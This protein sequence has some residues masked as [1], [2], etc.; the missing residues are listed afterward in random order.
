MRTNYIQFLK[1]NVLKAGL[2]TALGWLTSGTAFAQISGNYTINRLGTASATVYTS[3]RAVVDDL[4]GLS[5]SDGGVANNTGLGVTGAVTYRV[6]AGSGP[7]TWANTN[8]LII[9]A[10]PTT[11]SVRTVTFRGNNEI[12][13][14]TGSSSE[15]AAIMLDGAD[16]FRFDSIRLFSL[17]TTQCMGM[18]FKNNSDDNIVRNCVV[19]CPNVSTGQTATGSMSA[20]IAF[21]TDNNNLGLSQWGAN[22]FGSN[23]SRNQFIRNSIGGRN[24][25][26]SSGAGPAYGIMIVGDAGANGATSNVIEENLISNCFYRS[27]ASAF[28][29]SNVIN[30]NN[31][32][33]PDVNTQ[34]WGSTC[35]HSEAG[36]AGNTG[37]ITISNNKMYQN[38]GTN[39][40]ASTA[41][42]AI[43]LNDFSSG[44][45]NVF[46]NSIYDFIGTSQL[47]VLYH[48]SSRFGVRVNYH[49]NTFSYDND[50]DPFSPTVYGYMNYDNFGTLD[51]RNNNHHITKTS[52]LATRN[53]FGVYDAGW[54]SS[55]YNFN[56]I[57][58]NR[59]IAGVPTSG[60][61]H[62]YRTANIPTF[63]AWQASGRDINGTSLA[64]DFV[65]LATGDLRARTFALNNT[66]TNLLYPR[67][68][69]DSI[70]SLTTPDVGA[71]EVF[72][73]ASTTRWNF[74]A[75]GGNRCGN[76]TE[77]VTITIR[78]MNTFPIRNVPVS[79]QINANPAA[80]EIVA[81]PI[82]AGDTAVYTFTAIPRFNRPGANTIT[83]GIGVADDNVSNS[84]LT[85]TVNIT[86]TPE[87]SLLSFAGTQG[88]HNFGGFDV[89]VP[90]QPL[91]YSFTPP[92]GLTNADY[93]TTPANRWNI[94]T[95]VRTERAGILVT[96]SSVTAPSGATNALVSF[97]PPSS[98]IDSFVILNVVFT[99][100]FTGCDTTV[101][102]RIFVAPRCNP[103]FT[104]PITVCEGNAVLFENAST[105][106]TGNLLYRWE[107][108][109]NT[110]DTANS[111]NPVFTFP[112]SG[113]YRVKYSCITSPYGYVDTLSQIVTVTPIPV[114]NFTRVNACE[115]DAVVLTNSTVPSDATYVWN[116]GDGSPTSTAI[117]V[118]KN[119]AAPGGYAVTLNATK[120]GCAASRTKNVYQFAR[121]NA[122]ALLG[123]GSCD[124]DVFTFVNNTTISIGNTGYLWN[125]D[126]PNAISTEKN[127]SYKFTTPGTK[128]VRLTS[129]SEFGCTDSLNTSLVVVVKA[130]PKA[131]FTFDQACSQTSTVFSNTTTTPAGTPNS[132]WT[133]EGVTSVNNN[134][135]RNHN[136]VGLGKKSVSLS[137]TANGCTDIIT[138]EL[139]VLIQPIADFTVSDVCQG[140]P[141][142]FTNKTTWPTGVISYNWNFGDLN[143]SA[144][145]APLHTYSNSV[146]GQRNV[147]LTASIAGGC[148]STKIIPVEIKESPKACDFDFEKDYSKGLGVHKLVPKGGALTATSFKWVYSFGGSDV[149]N[150]VGKNDI[151]FPINA[152]P[153]SVTMVASKNGC[154]C[155]ITK[156]TGQSVN[157][158]TLN[159][160]ADV[161]VYPNPTNGMVNVEINNNSKPIVIEIYNAVGA[162]IADVAATETNGIF[163]YDLNAHPVGLYL[164]KITSGN[165][166]STVRITLTK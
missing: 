63:A 3:F 94:T 143:T 113:S 68:V 95:N 161:T 37:N 76:Y 111:T 144:D 72:V 71:Y 30:K 10:I 122:M 49:H 100:P 53:R 120:N 146:V 136:W 33:N 29:N 73:D 98:A 38:Y 142:I 58:V 60:D 57:F 115:G 47:Y 18:Q 166:T 149:T 101:R 93:G 7:Y 162:K 64:A 66:G 28:T 32:T 154:E 103:N 41:P 156:S 79:W 150:A 158:E 131:N 130:S 84:Q 45:A 109:A 86:K 134:A 59:G 55:T 67:D 123:T 163:S 88:I 91:V 165:Q 24:D 50:L 141:A 135:T 83:A 117:N 148:I 15:R 8:Q 118:N 34:T 21:T 132:T 102:K 119:Y 46:N 152:G 160:N 2:I 52:G 74:L 133:I 151:L 9:P 116:F 40:G 85:R 77:P 31:I 89:T 1:R 56:N 75:N 13:N 140:Q 164:V 78:N 105:V 62:G 139:D 87:G 26:T 82:A 128:N 44:T 121:P 81:G 147:T 27:V 5:R 65:N 14:Y 125:F 6:A 35:I 106:S 19:R 127:A 16:W 153:V 90:T 43:Y 23:G 107:F 80:R 159:L 69:N 92:T 4:R 145:G 137:V 97:N 54:G 129:V 12:I 17:A 11:S 104:F 99:D 110:E 155:S 96:G 42:Y 114:V 138:K 70:R 22:S 36:Q 108:T 20:A 39:Q 126:E 61:I 112:G 157:T 48:Y 124:N 51:F 25:G